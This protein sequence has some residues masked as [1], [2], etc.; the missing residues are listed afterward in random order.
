MSWTRDGLIR[1]ATIV[2]PTSQNLA[3]IEDNLRALVGANLGR[4]DALAD[5]PVRAG[6]PQPRS[7]HLV[8]SSLSLPNGPDRMSGTGAGGGTG[9]SPGRAAGPGG[10]PG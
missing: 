9:R 1:A 2:P 10:R 8:R 5:R 6:H 3:V 4:D 7:V